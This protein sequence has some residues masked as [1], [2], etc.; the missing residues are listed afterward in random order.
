[1]VF[2]KIIIESSDGLKC[3]PWYSSRM[4]KDFHALWAV[5]LIEDHKP[6]QM[7]MAQALKA[8]L[9]DLDADVQAV[10]VF[11]PDQIQ[12]LEP[13]FRRHAEEHAGEVQTL[14]QTWARDAGFAKALPAKVLTQH[15]YS[16]TTSTACLLDHARKTGANLIALAT[17]GKKGLAR[18]VMGSFAESLALQSDIPLFV[19]NADAHPVAEIR[20]ILFPTDFSDAGRQAFLQLLPVAAAAG[21]KLK[22][23]YKI[24]YLLPHTRHAIVSY[25]PYKAIMEQDLA[26][27]RSTAAEWTKIA[28]A[29][30]VPLD[31]VFDDTDNYV[32]DA[33]LSAA[34]T[35]KNGMIAMAS[36]RGRAAVLLGSV[37]RELL[38]RSPEPVWVLHPG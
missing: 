5:D 2:G 28:S 22:L 6:I 27:K 33:I 17:S 21:M 35:M 23:F 38:R 13:A 20:E 36:R 7:K 24:E 12:L 32:V 31:T 30:A 18:A 26:V 4:A 25:P 11:S 3:G 14:L 8:F 9:K 34:A 37:T 16:V 19:V 1:M 10:T 29:E 15:E